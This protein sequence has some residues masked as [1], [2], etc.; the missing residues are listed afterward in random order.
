[1]SHPG[2][3]FGASN[4]QT[5]AVKNAP[6]N[7][8]DVGDAASIP[9]SKR[10]PGGGHGN[11]LQYSFLENPMDLGAWMAVVHRVSKRLT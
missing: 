11:P 10:S 9:G 5:T 4:V 7:E 2:H 8:E 6:A 1:M 3:E